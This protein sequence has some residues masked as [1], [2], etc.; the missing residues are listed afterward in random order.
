MQLSHFD[1]K[2]VEFLRLHIFSARHEQQSLLH[3]L[4]QTGGLGQ[5]AR[6]CWVSPALIGEVTCQDVQD[7]HL[8][9][10][11]LLCFPKGLVFWLWAAEDE[12]SW[13]IERSYREDFWSKP[14]DAFW[15]TTDLSNIS[16]VGDP[17]KKVILALE[18]WEL[19]GTEQWGVLLNGQ[20]SALSMRFLRDLKMSCVDCLGFLL[21]HV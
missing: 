15:E 3:T 16:A 10:L 8:P 13:N 9:F 19:C 17:E 12:R 6:C 20:I 18:I 4:V 2:W 11:P 14:N 1:S 5:P 7:S 21:L